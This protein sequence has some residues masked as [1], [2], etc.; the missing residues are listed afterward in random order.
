MHHLPDR[1]VEMAVGSV[2]AVFAFFSKRTLSSYDRRINRTEEKQ[3]QI[4][5]ALGNLEKQVVRI[6]TK[7]EDM[8]K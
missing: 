4:L 3:D 6:A 5:C 7:L 2:L 8:G 1:F